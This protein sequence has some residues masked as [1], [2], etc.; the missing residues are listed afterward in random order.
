MEGEAVS[1]AF[2]STLD[3][4]PSDWPTIHP[5]KLAS[6]CDDQ[7]IQLYSYKHENLTYAT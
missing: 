4:G 5:A 3:D 2:P 1:V 6:Y 7:A